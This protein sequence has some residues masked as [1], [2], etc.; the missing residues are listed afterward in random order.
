MQSNFVQYSSPLT[1]GLYWG[2][3]LCGFFTHTLSEQ[4]LSNRMFPT[5]VKQSWIKR[6]THWKHKVKLKVYICVFCCASHWKFTTLQRHGSTTQPQAHQRNTVNY[7]SHAHLAT[8]YLMLFA[9]SPPMLVFDKGSHLFLDGQYFVYWSFHG[10]TQF[11]LVSWWAIFCL[12]VFSWFGSISTLSLWWA[13]SKNDKFY[14]N[15]WLWTNKSK[16]KLEFI[17]IKQN[18]NKKH[19]L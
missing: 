9:W 12:L 8:L 17:L 3:I 14:K 13:K 6:C 10:L 7:G 1:K 5:Q 16:S 2:P 4:E 19:I 18:Q 15:Q 11:Q